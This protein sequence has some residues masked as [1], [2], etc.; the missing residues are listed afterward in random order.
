MSPPPTSSP[1]HPRQSRRRHRGSGNGPDPVDAIV[2]ERLR[3]RR[4]SLGL[5]QRTLGETLGVTYD[6]EYGTDTVEMHA[7]AIG[8][9]DRVLVVDD[10]LATDVG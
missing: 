6:L 2:G 10:L 1:I 5:S 3:D 7:D 9:G 8:Q 4:Q